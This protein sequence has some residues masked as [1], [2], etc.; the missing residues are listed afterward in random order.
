M[1]IL[2]DY[3]TFTIKEYPLKKFLDEIN[4]LTVPYTNGGGGFGIYEHSVHFSGIHVFFNGSFHLECSDMFTISMSGKG[5]R[6]F[7]SL[8]DKNLDWLEF[9]GK[10]MRI[11][12]NDFLTAKAHIARLDI[13]CDDK[14]EL[15]E[16]PILDFIKLRNHYEKDKFICL[17]KKHTQSRG[18]ETEE[19]EQCIYFGSPRS[20][21]RIRIYNKALERTESG[22]PYDSHWIRC[23]MQLRND[24]ALS[25]YLKALEI[26]NIGEC[27]SGMLL[28]YLRFTTEPNKRDHNQGRLKVC[29][30]WLDFCNHSAKI[31]GF[32]IGGSEYN[33]DTLYNYLHKQASSSLLTY[34]AI[35]D[36][37]FSCLNGILE[38]ASLSP[39]QE[40][41]LN[42]IRFNRANE[43]LNEIKKRLIEL[44]VPTNE[45]NTN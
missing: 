30:W 22:K 10:Y 15:N 8:H 33:L 16:Q 44:G 17:A 20:D 34:L 27:F 4:F 26:G 11:E 24:T 35:H 14:P 12:N 25:F 39:K 36:G 5:C 43:N 41:L 13:A 45:E 40:K 28:D 38:D 6:A 19:F 18:T 42:E 1:N 32:K 7:E 37:D 2:V 29:K 21:R 23:E 3:L 31:K 9:I